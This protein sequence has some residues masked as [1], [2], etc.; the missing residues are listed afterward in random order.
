MAPMRYP[1]THK[2]L[3]WAGPT[4]VIFF[5]GCV[6][7]VAGLAGA[8]PRVRVWGERVFDQWWPIVTAPWFVALSILLILGYLAALLWT[9]RPRRPELDVPAAPMIFG[10]SSPASGP[11]WRDT[12]SGREFD[13][14]D[15]GPP[16][17]QE[18]DFTDARLSNEENRTIQEVLGRA[19]EGMRGRPDFAR[20]A[21]V[22]N[23]P[24]SRARYL[25][26]DVGLAEAIL[27]VMRGSWELTFASFDPRTE[28]SHLD[29]ATWGFEEKAEAGEIEVWGSDLWEGGR[30]TIIQPDEWKKLKIVRQSLSDGPQVTGRDGH[31]PERAY[32]N[33]RVNRAQVEEAWP[34]EKG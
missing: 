21:L 24:T 29:N 1:T 4:L 19:A 8:F 26:H 32:H 14:G 15:Y 3:A 13:M 6:G 18:S 2:F 34:R 9:G 30:Y 23:D 28:S 22:G 27:Y 17:N 10:P 33:L 5:G 11:P 31:L 12:I 20:R 25:R 16:P 7:L